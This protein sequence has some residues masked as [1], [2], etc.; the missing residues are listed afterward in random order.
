MLKRL[1]KII[2]IS[3]GHIFFVAGLVG[4]LIPLLPSTPFFLLA[5]WLYARGS[6]RFHRAILGNRYCGPV[7]KDWEKNKSISLRSKL[8][9]TAMLV[10]SF[11]YVL[12]VLEPLVLKSILAGF[13]LSIGLYIVSRPLPKRIVE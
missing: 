1:G 9:A 5:C 2:L 13:I 11:I 8:V 3:L 6:D 12:L 4:I 10:G 7:I